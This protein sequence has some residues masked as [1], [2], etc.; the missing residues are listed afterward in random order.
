MTLEVKKKKFFFVT[1]FH[2]LVVTPF[3]PHPHLSLIHKYLWVKTKR[4]KSSRKQTKCDWPIRFF[5]RREKRHVH[6]VC[7]QC[8][9]FLYFVVRVEDLK[10]KKKKSDPFASPFEFTPSS[11]LPHLLREG[12]RSFCIRVIIIIIFLFFPLVMSSFFLSPNSLFLWFPFISPELPFLL[13][14]SQGS[15]LVYIFSVVCFFF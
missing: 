4:K 1:V 9:F 13:F 7:F 3:S 15:C 14:C 2:F 6:V 5:E 11:P 10:K 12:G 8:F